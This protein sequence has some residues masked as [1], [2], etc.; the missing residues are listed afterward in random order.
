MNDAYTVVFINCGTSL[1]AGVVVYS[2]LG[3]REVKTGI[4][5]NKVSCPFKTRS[6]SDV[7]RARDIHAGTL[8][9]SPVKIIVHK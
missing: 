9:T 2:I 8:Q 5:A 4:P 6:V 3:Y 1:F 7:A